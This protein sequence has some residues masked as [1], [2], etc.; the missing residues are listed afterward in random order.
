MPDCRFRHSGS[1]P[2]GE[3]AARGMT[4]ADTTAPADNARNSRLR[5]RLSM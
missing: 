5:S 3:A 2:F 1:G 4:A